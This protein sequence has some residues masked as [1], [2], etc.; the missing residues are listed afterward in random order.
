M[1]GFFIVYHELMNSLKL[2]VVCRLRDVGKAQ[3]LKVSKTVQI[4]Y[5]FS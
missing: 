3:S 5:F 4:T 1:T 2:I